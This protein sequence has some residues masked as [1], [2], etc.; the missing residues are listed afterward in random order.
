MM[1][2]SAKASEVSSS[3]SVLRQTCSRARESHG[4][5]LV[6]RTGWGGSWWYLPTI[7]AL[8][9]SCCSNSRTWREAF[10]S[11]FV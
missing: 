11:T 1:R 5:Y 3:S 7:S 2:V 4:L 6:V 10:S 9:R 8:I